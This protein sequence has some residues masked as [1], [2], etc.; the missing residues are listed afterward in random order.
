MTAGFDS[1]ILVGFGGPT[2]GCCR[3][4]ADCPGE[5]FCYVQG[6]VGERAGGDERVREVAAHYARFGGVS[7]FS[8]FSQKQAGALEMA[9]ESAGVRVPVYTGYRFWNPFI[10]DTLADMHGAGL[11]RALGV[12][13]APHRAKISWE[14]YL[15]EVA[16]AR[17]ALG[18]AAPEVEFMDAP[19]YDGEGYVRAAA[20][21]IRE[22]MA[23]EGEERFGAARLIFTAH[24]IPVPMARVSPYEREF[25]ATAEGVARLL[26]RERYDMG[27]QSSPDV[28]PGTWL[29]PD[30]VSV[31]RRAAEEGAKDVLLSPVGFICDHVEVLFD[32][33]VEA[34]EAAEECGLGYFR[35]PTV[36]THPAFI[37]MLRDRV[38]GWVAGR[39]V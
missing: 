19:W 20:G 25:A 15:T 13:L 2:R 16:S 27:Y 24:S 37:E 29:G 34:R 22:A 10:R 36:G 30:A 7:P 38:A 39:R 12:V 18:G 33:D 1:V 14:A 21:R 35:A 28:P 6:I 23:G 8:F 11:R 3:R 5:A 4:H 26:G 31:I 17:E 32:L 9:L